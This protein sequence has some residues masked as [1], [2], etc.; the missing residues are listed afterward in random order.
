[1]LL[2][3]H[4]LHRTQRNINERHLFCHSM[5]GVIKRFSFQSVC[6]PKLPPTSPRC[7]PH[8]HIMSP[9]VIPLK[10]AAVISLTAATNTLCNAL[11]ERFNWKPTFIKTAYV[12]GDGVMIILWCEQ[13]GMLSNH[14][15]Y[16][17]M[18][19]QKSNLIS[20][21]TYCYSCYR[22]YYWYDYD[23]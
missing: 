21:N 14:N 9:H 15:G 10:M 3:S 6:G 18:F 17:H 1:M 8:H 20:N 23:W 4:L 5:L 19:R 2:A 11:N 22:L 13:T 12:V 7:P 16:L